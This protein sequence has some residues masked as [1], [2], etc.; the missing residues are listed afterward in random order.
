MTDNDELLAALEGFLDRLSP[1][2]QIAANPQAVEAEAAQI[3]AAF[4]RHA[5]PDGF[6][7]WWAQVTTELLRRMKTR[8]WPLVSEV[9]SACAAVRQAKGG[10]A[11]EAEVERLILD[12]M[13]DWFAL[14]KTQMPGYG[15][16]SRTVALIR[17]GVLRDEREARFRGFDMTQDMRDRAHQQAATPD[18]AA[19]HAAAL[20]RLRVSADKIAENTGKADG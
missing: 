4:D 20:E 11:S 9:E 10:A 19:A 7:E 12:R 14:R 3:L 8:A 18:E 1:P 13:T 16:P 6:A 5:P 2:R 17:R 15:K